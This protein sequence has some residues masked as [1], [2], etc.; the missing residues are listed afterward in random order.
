MKPLTLEETA[1]KEEMKE[2][3]LAKGQYIDEKAK[4]KFKMLCHL[5]DFEIQYWELLKENKKLKE[6]Y[7]NRTDCSGRI[8][9][10]R[11]YDSLYQKYNK[12]LDN[13]NKLKEYLINDINDRNGT[14]IAEFEEG[15]RVSET[16]SPIYTLMEDKSRT[17]KEVLDKMQELEQGSD[18]ND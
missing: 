8:K 16:I 4:D 11:E 18:S 7:C 12:Q 14:K 1:L 6:C 3:C 17:M 13:W 5:E 15:N 2:R 9:N 10:S